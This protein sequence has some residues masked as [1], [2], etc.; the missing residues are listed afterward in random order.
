MGFGGLGL[1]KRHVEIHDNAALASISGF[2][3]LAKVLGHFQIANNPV[4]ATVAG[5]GLLNEVDASFAIVHNAALVNFDGIATLKAIGTDLNI[6]FNS[7]LNSINSLLNSPLQSV[8]NNFGIAN[9]PALSSCAVDQLKLTLQS[10]KGWSGIESTCC[11]AGCAT[12]AAAVCNGTPVGTTGQSTI[13][14]GSPTIQTAADVQTLA[15]VTEIDGD[16]TINSTALTTL[17]GLSNLTHIT[18]SLSITAR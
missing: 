10:N 17:T 14:L 16:L 3:A 13:C 4:L 11:N 6:T 15:N 8:G 2:Q 18:G 9:N 7:A 5:F 12:C 1:A